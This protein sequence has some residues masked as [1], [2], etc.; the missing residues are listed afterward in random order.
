MLCDHLTQCVKIV[1]IASCCVF[2]QSVIL[3][4][5][6]LSRSASY[7]AMVRD[8]TMVRSV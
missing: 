3:S 2:T 4:G 8:H 6:V 7:C 5:V 1:P